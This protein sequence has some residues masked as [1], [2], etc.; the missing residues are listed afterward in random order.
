M[1]P[2]LEERL[3]AR[4]AAEKAAD[5]A[6]QAEDEARLRVL[7]ARQAADAAK[8]AGDGGSQGGDATKS[9]N[10][11]LGEVEGDFGGGQQGDEPEADLGLGPPDVGSTLAGLRPSL[12]YYDPGPPRH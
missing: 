10:A 3:E 9:G 12:A 1:N 8:Q 7:A 2:W 4:C 6:Q 5:E 11:A